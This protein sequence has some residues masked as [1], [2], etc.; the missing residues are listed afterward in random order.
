MGKHRFKLKMGRLDERYKNLLFTRTQIVISC[1][2]VLF[3]P[4]S[5]F[6]AVSDFS[7]EMWL[8]LKS[9]TTDSTGN[10]T[11]SNIGNGPDC[12]SGTHCSFDG[13]EG[14]TA[15]G[16]DFGTG[17]FLTN[18]VQFCWIHHTGAD[19]GMYFG[20]ADAGGTTENGILYTNTV[21]LR[22]AGEDSTATARDIDVASPDYR[23][24]FSLYA[25][26]WTNTNLTRWANTTTSATN[27]GNNINNLADWSLGDNLNNNF[28]TQIDATVCAVYTN[29]QNFGQTEIEELYTAGPTATYDDF[30]GAVAYNVAGTNITA[31][32]S[33]DDTQLDSFSVTISNSSFSSTVNSNGTSGS[34]FENLT[35]GN[36]TVNV[37]DSQFFNLSYSIELLGN[38]YT[39]ASN[40]TQAYLLIEAFDLVTGTRI[41]SF[42]TS[43]G[44]QTNETFNGTSILKV[45][46]GSRSFTLTHNEYFGESDSL[47]VENLSYNN[48]KFNLTKYRFNITATPVNGSTALDDYTINLTRLDSDF[49]QSI[50]STA[51]SSVL[52]FN[53]LNGTYK[54][55][56]SHPS[57]STYYQ[58]I[59][60]NTSMQLNL[61]I[62]EINT[63]NITFFDAQTLNLLTGENI[64][65]EII[66]DS[67]ANNY[68][69]SNGTIKA[70]LVIP[71]TYTFRFSS[72]NYLQQFS[73]Q[74]LSPSTY[75]NIALY[76]LKSTEVTNITAS[77][78]DETNQPVEGA[79]IKVLRYDID[80]NSFILQEIVETNFNGEAIL[81]A[82][83]N[84]EYYKFIVTY[85][86]E[87]KFQS[88]KTYITDT[89]L[90]F[91]I[92]LTGAIGEDYF[93]YLG[94]D[95][96]LNYNNNTN[97]YSYT[98]SDGSSLTNQ[99]CLKVYFR[100]QYGSQ[101]YSLID[102][103]CL[104]TSSGVISS[105]ITPQNG[106]FRAD[107]TVTQNSI[108]YTLT[109]KYV[110]FRPL[111]PFSND[112]VFWIVPLFVFLASFMAFNMS[113]GFAI[114]SLII[115]LFS[116]MG[117]L[118]INFFISIG[119]FIVGLILMVVTWKK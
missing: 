13:T 118:R 113:V 41:T 110:V 46:G 96:V 109:N 67:Y 117:L 100:P 89:T 72:E 40:L 82:Q 12:S 14:I 102:S 104:T 97:T 60:I 84:S 51:T 75:N 22:Y 9:D 50:E 20:S 11:I 57:Y 86:G 19:D 111:F 43:S 66:S 115:P 17:Q 105:T 71:D 85:N 62:L 103:S 107:A 55:T 42:N 95:F 2:I 114:S 47:T 54:I 44:S 53:V 108:E 94:I 23:G 101:I 68:T 16:L 112:L 73:N 36:Y 78:I 21:K 63:F 56:F 8:D 70:V 79:L 48:Y 1:L 65:L 64:T 77:V 74:V 28:G 59:T 58:N 5:A 81:H 37:S 27:T 4:L 92:T 15:G 69:T 90:S 34:F 80:T 35:T 83:L 49:V 38:N 6:G 106:T 88:A 18:V 7:P 61:S 32:D 45:S 33:Y 25:W 87:I 119:I 26:R 93:N 10:Y 39:I 52:T 3:I 24:S 29:A 30:Y 116:W 98:Y 76:M 31:Y 99:A 91:P